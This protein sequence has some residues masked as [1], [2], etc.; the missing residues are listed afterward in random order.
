MAT[1]MEEMG[2]ALILFDFVRITWDRKDWINGLCRAFYNHIKKAA[3]AKIIYWP[4]SGALADALVLFKL[5]LIE[6][7]PNRDPESGEPDEYANAI[8]NREWGLYVDWVDFDGS[9]FS[10]ESSSLAHYYAREQARD[11]KSVGEERIEAVYSQLKKASDEGL[12]TAHSLEAIHAVMSDLDVTSE[13][14]ETTITPALEN[15]A[16]RLLEIGIYV[17]DDTIQSNFM[18]YPLYPAIV[19]P[20]KIKNYWEA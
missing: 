1:A 15:V 2:K 16:Q 8:V 17:S 5:E 12:F 13:T 14:S 9:W 19:A 4:G 7:W 18:R 20:E 10:P 3:Y 11:G 6:Y